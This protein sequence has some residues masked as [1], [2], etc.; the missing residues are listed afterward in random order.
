MVIRT[1]KILAAAITISLTLPYSFSWAEDYPA[2]YIGPG[3]REYLKDKIMNGYYVKVFMDLES[4]QKDNIEKRNHT[5][6]VINTSY[7]ANVNTNRGT[8]ETNFEIKNNNDEFK[9][10]INQAQ[11]RTLQVA[12]TQTP[13]NYIKYSDGKTVHSQ[14]GLTTSIENERVVD[15]FGNVNIKNTYNMQYNAERMLTGFEAKV[16]D[17][18]GNI[19]HIYTSGITYSPSSVFYGGPD[20]KAPK[21][22]MERHTMEVDA[23]GNVNVAHWQA[24]SY[25]GNRLTAFS[26]T[27]EDS[28]YGSRSFSRTNIAYEDGNYRRVRSYQE[29]GIGADGLQYTS[30]KTNISY[31]DKNAVISYQEKTTTTQLDD[32]QV[33]VITDARFK[34]LPAITQFGDD[35]EEPEPD[36]LAEST[37]TTTTLNTDGSDKTETMVTA[38]TYDKNQALAGALGNN[39]IT[40]QEGNWFEYK[41]AAG[42]ALTL[43]QGENDTTYSYINPDTLEAVNIA[44]SNVIATLKEGNKYNGTSEIQY[45]I[46]FGRPMA[47]LMNS[48]ICYYG[49]N[50]SAGELSRVETSNVVYTNT[51]VNNTHRIIRTQEHKGITSPLMDPAGNYRETNDITTVYTYDEKGSLLDAAGSGIKEGYEYQDGRGWYGRYTAPINMEYGVIFGKAVRT[52]YDE[53]KTYY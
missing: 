36:K 38:Y 13:F 42:S 4:R 23:A 48:I 33:T 52:I 30:E 9:D 20:T 3:Y 29:Y 21:N 40:G 14:D 35:L 39:I 47:K 45:E 50:I 41:D 10:D 2:G 46:L 43:S 27:E 7:Q 24:I 12:N 8:I 51:L 18:L 11:R 6:K 26:Q 19:S 1:M 44:E 28:V 49:H 37:I 25:D 5:E 16:K 31:N 22:E 34:Y 32:G 53:E 17:N 15:E